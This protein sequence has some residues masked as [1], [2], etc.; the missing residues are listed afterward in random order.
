MEAKNKTIQYSLIF[1]TFFLITFFSTS[2]LWAATYYVAQSAAGGN[3]GADCANAK[4]L[5]WFNSNGDDGDT[6][7]LCDGTY[8]T[9]IAPSNSG[10]SG[11]PITYIADN[12]Y[13]AIIST[14][15]LGSNLSGKSYIILDGLYFND[16]GYRWILITNG[17]YNIIQNCKFY[18][19]NA[20]TGLLLEYGSHYNKIID[21]IFEDAPASGNNN[22]TSPADFI[23]LVAENSNY[24]VVEGNTFGDCKH[25]I[26]FID[27]GNHT[28]IRCNTF[29]N[30]YHTGLNLNDDGPNLIEN[31]YFYDQGNHAGDNPIIDKPNMRNNPGIQLNGTYNIIRRNI[32]DNNG[33]GISQ[34]TYALA[35]TE[36]N[37]NMVY[38]NTINKGVIPLY[39]EAVDA[40]YMVG[41]I[42]KNNIF[43]NAERSTFPG[44]S[45]PEPFNLNYR[46]NNGGSNRFYNNCSYGQNDHRFRNYTPYTF[47][48]IISKYSTIYP[49]GNITTDPKYTNAANRNFTL[50][51]S[52][53]MIDAGAWLTTITNSTASGV[54]SFVVDDSRYFYDGWGIQGETGD[55]IKTQNGEVTTIQSINYDTHTITV[56]PAIHIVKGEGLALNY[57]GSAPE[58]GAY[59]YGA[60]DIVSPPKEL[61]IKNSQ[62]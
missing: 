17:D 59:E 25:N 62:D 22:G 56:S 53:P 16:C 4:S 18:D 1:L 50:Q 5:S 38:N 23:G 13:G 9:Q 57:S 7:V 55:I 33:S 60:S 19:S 35:N 61:K 6:A 39:G 54:S 49:S 29:Q 34:S 37:Y 44:D 20:W 58:I 43:T 24:N 52:S 27:K 11:N 10:S 46:D 31:N 15:S 12:Q 14:R 42:Y 32:F 51:G 40:N 47:A 21:N 48:E 3:T 2:S 41:N 8:T 36:A 28:V 45:Y 30:Q 26:M